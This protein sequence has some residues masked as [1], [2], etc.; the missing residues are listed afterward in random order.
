MRRNISSVTIESMTDE[1]TPKRVRKGQQPEV[2]ET[3]PTEEVVAATPTD[4]KN[5][6]ML[7]M[8]FGAGWS[9]SSG[10]DFSSTHPYAL[11]DEDEVDPMLMTG[12]FR[13]ASGEEVKRYYTGG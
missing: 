11:V 8:L 13:Q 3:T 1:T 2:D 10:A 5:K 7:V 6:T 9:T 12:R 4:K